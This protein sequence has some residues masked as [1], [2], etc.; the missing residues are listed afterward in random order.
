RSAKRRYT[1]E[2]G[3]KNTLSFKYRN[4][5]YDLTFFLGTFEHY[6]VLIQILKE[7]EAAGIPF[8]AR[9]A[10]HDSYIREQVE[11]ARGEVEI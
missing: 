9:S 7:W 11:L 1:V 2:H 8:K 5:P 6:D 4:I 3:N 10:F